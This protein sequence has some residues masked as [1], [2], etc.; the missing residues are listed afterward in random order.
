MD[1]NGIAIIGM[2]FRFPGANNLDQLWRNLCEGVE[3]ITFFS[4]DELDSSVHPDLKKDS[5]YVKARGVIDGADQFD[6]SFFRISPREAQI[7][8]P[9]QRLF[10]E[11][12]WEALEDAGYNPDTYNGLIGV[13]GGT[14]HNSYFAHHVAARP[15]IMESFGE[16][17]TNLVNAPDYLATR[18]SYKL[19]LRGPSISLYTGCSTSLVAVC[20]ACE[21]LL[22]YQ[23]DLALAGASFVQCPLDTG[24]L[25]QEGEIVSPD[26]HCRPF[27]ERARG[28][29]FSDG[30]GMVLLK[31]IEEA[32]RDRDHIYAVIKGTGIN[33]DGSDKVSF[34]APS[35]NGQAGAVAMAQANAGVDPEDISFVETHGTGTQLGDPIEIEALTQA[36]RAKTAKNQ[37]CAIGSLKGN[38]GHLDAAAGVA[39]LIKTA[40]AIHY[41]KIPPSLNFQKANPEIDFN[42][43][44]FFVNTKLVEWGTD[45]KPLRAGVSSFGVGGTNSHVVLEEAPQAKL[46]GPSRPWSLIALSAKTESALENGT[47]NLIR[48]LKDHPY[49]NMADVTYSL[50]VGRKSFAHRRFAVCKDLKDAIAK[51]ESRDPMW[52]RTQLAQ[53]GNHEVVFMFSGQGAQYPNMGLD[54]YKTERIFH[55]EIDRC[56][57]VLK[58]HLSVD[59]RDILYPQNASVEDAARRL[60]ETSITQPVLF[61]I[62]Y[63]LARLWMSW[64]ISPQAMVGHSIGEYVAACLSGVISLEDALMLVAVRGRLMQSLPAGGMLGIELACDQISNYLT[65]GLSLATVNTPKLCVVSGPNEEVT[66]LE[67]K[68]T[69]DGVR[70]TRL[71]TSHAFHSSM[72]DPILKPFEATVASKDL[73]PPTIP[74][75]SNVSGTWIRAEEAVNPSHWAKHL[76]NTVNFSD[77]LNE[78]LKVPQRIFLEVGPGHTLSVFA[79]QHPARCQEHVILTS[80]RHPKE[81]D[82]DDAFILKTLGHLWM[83]GMPIEWSNYYSEENRCRLPLPTYA[84]DR[85]RSWIDPPKAASKFQVE[86]PRADALDFSTVQ[87]ITEAGYRKEIAPETEHT[88]KTERTVAN[89]FKEILGVDH[90]DVNDSFFNMG[91]SSLMAVSLF[92]R[93]EKV[94]NRK[95]P[96]ATLYEA[97]TVRQ[98]SVI[99]N[100]YNWKAPWE[101]LVEV[102]TG[103]SK[104]PLF[105]V[106]GAGGNVLL[107]RELATHLGSNQPVY[108]FQSQGLDGEKP[109]VTTVEEMAS[110]YVERLKKAYPNGPYMLGGYCMGGSVALE[111]AQKLRAQGDEVPLLVFFE[112]YNYSKIKPMSKID[113]LYYY[114]Q[115]VDFHWRNFCLL[116]SN[117]KW[118]FVS[119]KAKV[120]LARKDVWFGM[121]GAKFGRLFGNKNGQAALLASIWETNDQAA[122][123]Y[124]PKPYIGKVTQFLPIREY[125]HHIGPE[126]GWE[127]IANGGLEK[128]TLP[129]YPAG[130][131][132]EPFVRL[133]A[134]KLTTCINKAL[135]S[136]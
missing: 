21:S 124:V 4:D 78:L 75:V 39:S 95:L 128:Y 79:R 122:Y 7:M 51:L 2:A 72:M 42:N 83:V 44:P 34:T 55:T 15:D 68:L 112:T 18:V 93:I 31:R 91:G 115:K 6:A 108:G 19:N 82:P 71:H 43:S 53:A 92:A 59:I 125:A 32:I 96:I 56:A 61:A 133:L 45:H 24:Y 54:L 69:G 23:C 90:V 120:A 131:L 40:L 52:T 48:Y 67:N 37:F 35:V 104:P 49:L 127:G 46:T 9:Q 11:A 136:H 97:P 102:Q 118:R 36:F 106:H 12:A 73:H 98:L 88:D 111:M 116:S 58:P 113:N 41:R 132:V 60:K 47:G 107:Y 87:D 30:V 84:F 114:L 50:Q 10:M 134:E 100:D 109:A 33:N 74:F 126:L 80:L 63:G 25:Y 57:E 119:E 130:M 17:Q 16:H 81:N 76:R 110:L 64:G 26:G 77:C 13:F 65:G 86:G 129:V 3:S 70:C 5:R 105:L 66:E 62:E 101:T 38:I 103:G 28:T 123:K 22:S 99:I 89:I 20:Y 121:L 29:V 14:G 8:D 85:K 94:F 1:L 117:E 135:D 27:D